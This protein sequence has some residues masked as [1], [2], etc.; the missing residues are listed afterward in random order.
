MWL[1]M[2]SSLLQMSKV[3]K[4]VAARVGFLLPNR[5]VEV[6]VQKEPLLLHKSL[7]LATFTD[8]EVMTP[9]LTL[10]TIHKATWFII[11]Q[12]VELSSTNSKILN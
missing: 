9:D 2:I 3:M 10:N 7:K 11:R 5:C 6:M 8:I 4:L 12:A 1:M